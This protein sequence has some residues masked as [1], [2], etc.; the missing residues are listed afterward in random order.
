MGTDSMVGVATLLQGD[1]SVVVSNANQ[2]PFNRPILIDADNDAAQIETYVS[3]FGAGTFT[4]SS[5]LSANFDAVI[6]Y[7]IL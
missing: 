2:T 1:T 5:R 7:E 6:A 4:I 3:S